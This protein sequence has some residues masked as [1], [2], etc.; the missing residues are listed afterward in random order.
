MPRDTEVAFAPSAA[1]AN[2]SGR[3]TIK[4]LTTSGYQVA[5]NGDNGFVCMV[6][7][8]WAAPTY[9]LHS[10]AISCMTRRSAGPFAS[11]R[12]PRAP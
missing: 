5:H 1:L 7:R 2:I 6:M 11:T 9:T 10:S 12:K 3:A 8:G 4:V